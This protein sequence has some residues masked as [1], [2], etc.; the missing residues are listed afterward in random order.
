MFL[1]KEFFVTS[2]IGMDTSELTAFD[3]ALKNAGVSECNLVPVSSILPLNSK[4]I[5]PVKII[6][7]TI[8][9]CVMTRMD[10]KPGE[11]IGAGLAYGFCERD[12]GRFGIVSE[13]HGYHSKEYL[14]HMLEEKL[15]RMAEIR[16][17]ELSDARYYTET[18]EVKPDLMG[19]V[20][21]L[22]IF[23]P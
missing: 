8:T 7:G 12:G 11:T 6:P 21:V 17:L 1:P 14:R 19:T 5:E 22:L 2:G 9:F 3:L 20:I 23:M 10:G 18:C 16:G 15:N 4:E 13:H